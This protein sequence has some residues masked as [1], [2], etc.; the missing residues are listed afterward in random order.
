MLLGEVVSQVDELPDG[1]ISV[2]I[3]D[4]RFCKMIGGPG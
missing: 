4:H 1:L 2:T 3:P